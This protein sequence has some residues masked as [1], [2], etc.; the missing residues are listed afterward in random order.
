MA[1]T[2]GDFFLKLGITGT[3]KV[4]NAFQKVDKGIKDF[5]SSAF[6]A[7]G[8]LAALVYGFAKMT[9]SAGN[10]GMQLS[11][12]STRTGISAETFQKFA[13]AGELAG[14]KAEETQSAINNLQKQMDEF[15]ISGEG[16]QWFHELFSKVGGDLN[17]ANDA[18][19]VFGKLQEYA[20]S[21]ATKMQKRTVLSSFGLGDNT[22]AAMMNG[23]YN[24]Q[25]MAEA[26]IVDEKSI[27]T[28]AAINTEWTKFKANVEAVKNNL[29]AT[30][31]GPIASG[32]GNFLSVI[33]KVINAFIEFSKQSKLIQGA[34][35]ILGM[36]FEGLGYILEGIGTALEVI[37]KL[38]TRLEEIVG[39]Y[40][41]KLGGFLGG[42]FK[43]GISKI[44]PDDLEKQGFQEENKDSFMMT[45]ING[46]ER[47]M[48]TQGSTPAVLAA[49]AAPVM[50][51]SYM[52]TAAD[53]RKVTINQTNNFT[54]ADDNP[55]QLAQAT[56][57]AVNSDS[58]KS[59]TTAAMR[60]MIGT[61]GG[62]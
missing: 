11:L 30:F 17:K 48:K 27:K 25:A 58:F 26:P 7:K 14:V 9:Q 45:L 44:L 28:L 36:A 24:K 31:A 10:F 59:Q 16:P 5:T 15:Q 18:M 1:F 47:L 8:A 49:P 21:N 35:S 61:S 62:Y 57:Q 38:F 3:D 41:G 39:K 34:L 50:S 4:T 22:I 2:V 23:A 29:A 43:K 40:L 6:F 52:N 60:G 19:Y 53:N 55:Q 46:F 20:L 13:Y 54:N 32:M 42:L 37:F 12:L 56:T 51:R 33:F